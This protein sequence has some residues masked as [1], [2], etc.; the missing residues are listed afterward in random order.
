MKQF[1]KDYLD[2]R[3]NYVYYDWE[4]IGT[5]GQATDLTDSL[6]NKLYVGDIVLCINLR[7][8]NIIKDKLFLSVVFSTE[9]WTESPGCHKILH[10]K[11]YYY[12]DNIMCNY[13]DP[14]SDWKVIKIRG[15]DDITCGE[16]FI[17]RNKYKYYSYS[18]H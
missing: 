1:T 4:R 11:P 6:G 13:N 9:W 8:T 10:K 14:K 17:G 16:K 7:K 5:V 15:F 3:P 2:N 18:K 12:V